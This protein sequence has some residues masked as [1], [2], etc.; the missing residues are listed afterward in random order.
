MVAISDILPVW[1]SV[2]INWYLVLCEEAHFQDFWN[3]ADAVIH[4]H[5]LNCP[6]KEASNTKSRQGIKRF[7]VDNQEID[8]SFHS[9]AVSPGLEEDP[10]AFLM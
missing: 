10:G 7:Y 9:G 2:N 3:R 1:N 4:M 6:T 5:W 8:I